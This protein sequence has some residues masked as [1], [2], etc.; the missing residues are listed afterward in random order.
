MQQ[1]KER[2]LFEKAYDKENNYLDYLL[3]A[4][5]KELMVTLAKELVIYG[6]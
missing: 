4:S 2:N 1:R 3:D 6:F 5:I